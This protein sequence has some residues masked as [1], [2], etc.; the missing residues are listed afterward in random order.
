MYSRVRASGLGNFWPYHPS[1]TCG[2]DTPSPRMWRPP[3]RWSNVSDAI[4]H[5][6]GV[7][8]DSCTT[9]VPSRSRLV[10]EPHHASGVKASLP[11]ASAVNTV[12]KPASSAAAT[13]SGAF[14]G[15][16]APQYP[17]CKPSFI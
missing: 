14:A 7:R 3:E 5:A 16:C 13:S 1:T 11:H 15:G 9:E 2:P 10:A 8:A 6:V 17:S 4:A 12:S